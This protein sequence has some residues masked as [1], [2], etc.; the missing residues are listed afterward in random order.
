MFHLTLDPCLNARLRK[1]FSLRLNYV[2]KTIVVWAL[3][4]WLVIIE[5][6]GKKGNE[7][8]LTL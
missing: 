2:E 1:A 5:S 6:G 7:A 4:K 8:G 3:T